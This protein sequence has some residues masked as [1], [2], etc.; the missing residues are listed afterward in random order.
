MQ[1]N[2]RT[3]QVEKLTHEIDH[4]QQMLLDSDSRT[5]LIDPS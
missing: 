2:E 5:V 4:L 1:A 3:K